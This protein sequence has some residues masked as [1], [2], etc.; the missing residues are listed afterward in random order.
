[1]LKDLES[2]MKNE[3]KLNEDEKENIDS[4]HK[5]KVKKSVRMIDTIDI[6]EE[7]GEVSNICLMN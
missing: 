5:K 3:E 1:M 4:T 2:K 6:K 7:N